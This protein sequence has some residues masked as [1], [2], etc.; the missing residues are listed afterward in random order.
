MYVYHI[1]RSLH[2]PDAHRAHR[3]ACERVV[4]LAP[5]YDFTLIFVCGDVALVLMV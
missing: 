3:R 1:Y 5:W 2:G 4:E